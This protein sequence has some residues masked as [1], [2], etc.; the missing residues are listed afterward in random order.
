MTAIAHDF[1]LQAGVPLIRVEAAECRNGNTNV[2]LRQAEFSRDDVNK[3]PLRWRVPVITSTLGG[4]EVRTLVSDG[5][6]SITVPGCE[7]LIVNRGQTGYYRTLYPHL[8]SS[9][10]RLLT[11]GSNRS[12]NW[13]CSRTIGLSALPDIN[14]RLPPSTCSTPFP[15]TRI[16]NSGRGPPKS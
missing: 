16:Q 13:V 8:C 6:G 10:L 11:R 15:S 7:P 12:I 9:D 4:A 5:T 14:R 1:T 3:K 2:T